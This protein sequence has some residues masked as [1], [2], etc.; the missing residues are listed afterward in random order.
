MKTFAVVLSLVCASLVAAQEPTKDTSTKPPV[1][2]E[3]VVVTGSFEPVPLSE[4]ERS[5]EVLPLANDRVLFQSWADA[6]K[7]DSS[8]DLRQRGTNGVQGDLSIRGSSFGQTLVLLNGLRLND[9]QSGHHNLDLP[10]PFEAIDRIEVL[11]GSGSTLY[12]SDAVGG[13]VNFITAA[14]S[15]TELRLRAGGG[16]FGSDQEGASLAYVAPRWS[17]QLDFDR[18]R[19]TG[20][21]TDR[22]YRVMT[23]GSETRFNTALGTSDVLL[24]Y[25]DRPFGADQFYGNYNSWE[26]TKG[27]FA[28]LSQQLG[29]RT[30]F[31]VG[32][33]RHTD[34]F[35][36]KR[37]MPW[38]YENNHATEGWQFALRRRDPLHKNITVFYGAEGYR[39]AIDSSNLGQHERGRGAVYAGADFRMKNRLSMSAGGREEV[40]DQGKAQF[41][42]TVSAGYWLRERV[43]LR[44]SVSRAFR[45]PTYTDLYYHDPASQGDPALR[46][47]S[48]WSYE[49]GAEFYLSKFAQADVTVFH[50][51]E[52]DGIDYV[53]ANPTTVWQAANIQNLRFTGIEATLRFP[54]PNANQIEISYTGLHGAQESLNGL[55]SRYTF[56]Y[57]I[58]S[59]V[60]AWTG[61]LPG[62]VQGRTRIGV[63]ERY[64]REPYAV[65]DISAAKQFG[66]VRP[67][68][69]MTNLTNTTYQE[70]QGVAMPGRAFMAG[71]EV[72]VFPKNK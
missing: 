26:R 6:L 59:G 4:I 55:Y 10:I 20:F 53:R 63:L 39:D 54:L 1:R 16:S 42:P 50:R 49:G 72:V 37:D 41:S 25:S 28:A 2:E 32:Y 7:L 35:I 3:S 60:I 68:V 27:W 24:A 15:V 18:D 56:N 34:V 52:T 40:F 31:S 36:L 8:L 65:W 9:A 12:G 43:K 21:A 71:M 44:G 38:V 58:Q 29:S 13:T 67:Y 23:L 45:L 30:A 22:D 69:Q 33:R 61:T 62:H 11:R 17:E 19:S 5:V 70:I 48:A 51:R 14:P 66:R 47:E 64:A 46:P 57:P